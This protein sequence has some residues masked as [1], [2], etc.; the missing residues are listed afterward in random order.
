MASGNV[1]A[2]SRR[3]VVPLLVAL[4]AVAVGCSGL[5]PSEFDEE[6]QA[7]GGGLGTDVPQD[8]LAALE[9]ELGEEPVLRSLNHFAGYVTMEALV[10]GTDDA[11]DSYLFGTSSG[12]GGGDGVT[13]PTPV[14]GVG[15]PGELRRELFRASRVP[16]EDF[17]EIVDDALERA[18]LT[19]GWAESLTVHRADGGGLELTVSVENERE[20]V[21]FTFDADGELVSSSGQDPA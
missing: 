20:S 19:G 8:G 17:D 14:T 12:Y 5:S 6:V 15:P 13:D 9:E 16:V 11:L 21:S 3:S 2:V 7:R 4:V 18:D 1:S 10:P